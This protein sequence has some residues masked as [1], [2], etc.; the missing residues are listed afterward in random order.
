MSFSLEKGEAF[1]VEFAWLVE[2]NKRLRLIRQ[3]DQQ[4][5]WINVTLMTESKKTY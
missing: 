2:P 3:Y 1:F 5:R 4:G